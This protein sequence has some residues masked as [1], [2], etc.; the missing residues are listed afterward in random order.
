MHL[1]AHENDYE[2]QANMH[3]LGETE[4]QYKQL[5]ERYNKLKAKYQICN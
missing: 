3:L 2:S 1:L 4:H 5:N